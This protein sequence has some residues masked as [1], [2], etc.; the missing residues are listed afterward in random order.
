MQNG[1][2]DDCSSPDWCK[3]SGKKNDDTYIMDHTYDMIYTSS[4][5][6]YGLE[7]R[8]HTAVMCVVCKLQNELLAA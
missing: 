1:C 2:R 4:Y 5:G 3:T 6:K 7:E 8:G